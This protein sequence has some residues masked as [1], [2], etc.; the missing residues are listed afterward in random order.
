[1]LVGHRSVDLRCNTH[2]D[3]TA[4]AGS[5]IGQMRHE[6]QLETSTAAEGVHTSH[7]LEEA[8]E[9]QTTTKHRVQTSGTYLWWGTIRYVNESLSNVKEGMKCDGRQQCIGHIE[10]TT[11]EAIKQTGYSSA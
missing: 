5:M 4:E 10:H 8:L 1:M 7:I 6:E 2:T 9:E 11:S 3:D